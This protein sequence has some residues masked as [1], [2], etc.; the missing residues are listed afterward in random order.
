MEDLLYQTERHTLKNSIDVDVYRELK[1]STERT[2]KSPPLE[3]SE[4]QKYSSGL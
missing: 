3:Q 2:T 4:Q 1:E